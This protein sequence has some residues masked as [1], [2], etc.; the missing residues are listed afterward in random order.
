MGKEKSTVLSSFSLRGQTWR[1]VITNLAHHDEPVGRW[2]H[3]DCLLFWQV[4]LRVNLS[5]N[6]R[7]KWIQFLQGNV[8]DVA[9]VR[10]CLIDWSEY[11]KEAQNPKLQAILK[12]T[13]KY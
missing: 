10:Y 1:V 4:S 7:I 6:Y 9:T 8:I 11:W 3:G 13:T 12:N 5:G 2:I